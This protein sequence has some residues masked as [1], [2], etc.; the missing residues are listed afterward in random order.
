LAKVVIKS[1]LSGSNKE[2]E[3]ELVKQAKIHNLHVAEHVSE[4][5]LFDVVSKQMVLQGLVWINPKVLQLQ[6]LQ[7]LQ[8]SD[9]QKTV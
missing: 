2:R 9:F 3:R 5:S 1:T 8:D 7:N 4:F 6:V